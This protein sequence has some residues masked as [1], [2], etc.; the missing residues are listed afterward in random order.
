MKTPTVAVQHLQIKNMLAVFSFVLSPFFGLVSFFFTSKEK[1]CATKRKMKLIQG[2][3]STAIKLI[4]QCTMYWDGEREE[5]FLQEKTDNRI[6]LD[7]AISLSSS[8]SSSFSFSSG[9]GI[10]ESSS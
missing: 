5:K 7:P 1:K 2:N 9:R 3:E 8:S 4:K 6:E 10:I